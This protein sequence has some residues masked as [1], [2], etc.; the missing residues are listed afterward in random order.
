M[1][2]LA[3]PLAL[4]ATILLAPSALAQ[5]ISGTAEPKPTLP[6]PFYQGPTSVA[7]R[8]VTGPIDL[9]VTGYNRARLMSEWNYDLDAGTAQD[10]FRPFLD[11]RSTIGLEAALDRLKVVTSVDLAGSDFDEG[12][13]WG[14]DNPTRQRPSV[15]NLRHLY[16]DYAV[17]DAGFQATIGRQRAHLGLGIVSSINR[18][19]IKLTQQLGTW[20]PLGPSN[21]TA[22]WVRGADGNTQWPGHMPVP[23]GIPV[24]TGSSAATTTN[25]A[26]GATHDLN[27]LVLSYNAIPAPGHRLQVFG[28]QQFDSS[29]TGAY[30]QKRYADVNY[31]GT[32]GPF[33][34]GVELIHLSGQAPAATTGLRQ[35]LE[36]YA[37]F[38][39]GT[40]AL[41]PIDLG[42]TLGQGGGDGNATDNVNGNFQSLFTDEGA[43]AFN[44]LFGDDLWGSNGTDAGIGR[45]VGLANVTFLQPSLGW[46]ISE[47]AEARISYT[48]HWA[49]SPRVAGSGIFGTPSAAGTSDIGDEVDLRLGHL[50]GS[51]LIYGATSVF[52]PGNVFP[53]PGTGNA[54]YKLELGTE[55][56]F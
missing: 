37:G 13:I 19:S 41:G 5:A 46:R 18:D 15:L 30:P 31:E 21:V 16:L 56:R 25:D 11:L 4:A 52:V 50:V 53:A 36:S 10:A 6:N 40:Y 35:A 55:V 39:T 49:T 22:V 17:K 45:G 1:K 20:G 8:P 44:H 26:T 27:A 33:R 2:H 34:G 43:L 7:P 51:S 29:S 48:K 23:P 12:L 3:A 54:A 38:L 28:A 42:L 24:A 32:F 9:K 47:R 14:W